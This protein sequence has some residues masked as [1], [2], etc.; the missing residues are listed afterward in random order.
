MK[1]EKIDTKNRPQK[2]ASTGCLMCIKQWTDLLHIGNWN[3][4]LW[5]KEVIQSINTWLQEL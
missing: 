2:L 5:S 3:K 4:E 1:M